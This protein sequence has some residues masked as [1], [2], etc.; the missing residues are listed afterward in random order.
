MGVTDHKFVLGDSREMPELADESVHLMV[1]SPPYWNLKDYG[2]G[3]NEI[4]QGDASYQEYLDGL[5]DVFRECVR[6]L[7][8]DGKLVINIMPLFLTGK[9]TRFNRRVTKTVLSD[10]EL[11]FQGL[12]NMF[13]LSLYIWDKRKVARFSSWGSYPY[14]ANLLSTYPYEWIIV[15]SKEGKRKPMAKDIKEAS[16]ITHEEWANWVINSLWEMQPAS[17]KREGHPAPFPEELP[18]RIIKIHSFVG[19]TVLDPFAGSGTTSK[20]AKELGRN[21][22]AYDI[23]DEYLDIF[24]KKVGWGQ[25][26]LEESHTYSLVDRRSLKKNDSKQHN[27]SLEERNMAEGFPTRNC[28]I[29]GETSFYSNDKKNG[30]KAGKCRECNKEALRLNTKL[31]GDACFRLFGHKKYARAG[32]EWAELPNQQRRKEIDRQRLINA[33]NAG[34]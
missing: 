14:P 13:F 1:T 25:Q 6:V 3:D 29:H 21:S 30:G 22:V 5:F 27:G 8:P 10:I 2:V 15:F 32:S 17:S 11:F 19:D 7:T 26:G 12:D 24:K 33:E 9:S 34:E 20:V 4:G 16:K 18:R 31:R 28:P 23:N